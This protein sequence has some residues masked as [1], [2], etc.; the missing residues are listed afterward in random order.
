MRSVT[1]KR[2]LARLSLAWRQRLGLTVAGAS[3]PARKAYSRRLQT[4]RPRALVISTSG[5]VPRNPRRASSKS[6]ASSKGSAP[7]TARF[8]AVV[9]GVA[10]FG[11]GASGV[12]GSS[13]AQRTV[14]P[15][16]A[17]ERRRV[18]LLRYDGRVMAESTIG[19]GGNGARHP[20]EP[21]DAAEIRETA[22]V[23]RA[24]QRLGPGVK[25]IGVTLHEP[26]RQALRDFAAG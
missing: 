18:N 16:I 24:G 23:L 2:P 7:S 3:G 17:P 6:C 22:A 12:I 20:L 4:T 9:I 15:T 8:C 25:V 19:A 14:G 21:L 5:S 1:S 11:P 10:S 26:T 13:R